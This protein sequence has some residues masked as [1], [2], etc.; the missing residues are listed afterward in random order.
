[1]DYKQER[2]L[3]GRKVMLAYQSRS[4][5]DLLTPIMKQLGAES[6]LAGPA[7]EMLKQIELAKPDVLFC[8]FQMDSLDG[9]AFLGQ[10]RREFGLKTPAILVVDAQD[11][12]A[13]AK[14]RTAGA[15]EVLGMP[16]SVHDV[17]NSAKR[18]LDRPE[19]HVLRFGP[20]PKPEDKP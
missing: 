19:A 4:L 6:V 13:T 9:P 16:F 18:A 8:E 7:L 20:R 17:T 10:V 14:A 3:A 11:G 15:N 2:I 1:M 5:R 12:E